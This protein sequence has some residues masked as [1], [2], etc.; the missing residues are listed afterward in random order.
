MAV[1]AKLYGRFLNT[2]TAK[3]V[4]L[5][6]DTLKAML[7][8]SSYVPDQDTHEFKSDVTNEVVGT[9]YTAGGVTLTGVSATY[10]GATNTWALD[11][12]DVA[13]PAST[14]TARYLIVYDATPGS[15]ATRRLIAYVDFGSNV[16]TTAGTLTVTWAAGGIVTVSV[17]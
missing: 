2:F 3:D 17:A 16:S 9:G 6:A 10:T 12:G 4:D 8:T 1:S 15:D 5:D 7:C 11:A 14:L 13:W